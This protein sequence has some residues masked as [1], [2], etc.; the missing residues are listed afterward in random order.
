M[1]TSGVLLKNMNTS[2][3]MRMFTSHELQFTNYAN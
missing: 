1:Q 3:R 2:K